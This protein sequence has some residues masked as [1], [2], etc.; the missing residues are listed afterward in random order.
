MKLFITSSRGVYKY[1]L[2]SDNISQII[3]NWNKGIFTKP[4]KGFFGIC[5]KIIMHG[6]LFKFTFEKFKLFKVFISR[7]YF[8]ILI[9]RAQ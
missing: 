2:K 9:G 5:F 8:F 3:S 7:L 1:N 6:N 4:S